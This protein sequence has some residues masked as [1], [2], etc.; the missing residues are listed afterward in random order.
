MGAREQNQLV[1][2]CHVYSS[3]SAYTSNN[4]NTSFPARSSEENVAGGAAYV[5]DF[6]NDK[7]TVKFV[8]KLTKEDLND[9]ANFGY[10]VSISG[11]F[12]VVGAPGYDG[13]D[14]SQGAAYVYHKG[15]NDW[16][17]FSPAP[18]ED[19][20]FGWS[21]S[22]NTNGVIAVSAPGDRA[23]RGS[24]YIF[25]PKESTSWEHVFTLEPDVPRASYSGW[26]VA[27]DDE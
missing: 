20:Y 2:N 10:S 1:C 26:S 27:I 7:E 16:D 9:F 17:L 25:K 3:S 23:D 12:V 24:V 8:Q 11:K 13:D 18:T 5:Y 14:V 19:A 22:V 4:F 6:D 15:S 21:V